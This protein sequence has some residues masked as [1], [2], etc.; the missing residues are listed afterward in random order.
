MK[1]L[2]LV[3]SFL[4]CFS[5]H[6]QTEEMDSLNAVLEEEI[7]DSTRIVVLTR[8]SYLSTNFNPQ[9]GAEIAQQAVSLAHS[10]RLEDLKAQALFEF[11]EALLYSDFYDSALTVFDSLALILDRV[12]DPKLSIH[13]L[14]EKGYIF[15][16]KGE[17]DNALE[18]SFKAL[19]LLDA[20]DYPRIKARV[21]MDIAEIFRNQEDG[22]SAL[23]YNMQA[24]ETAKE[25]DLKQ[26][27]YQAE[28][29]MANAYEKLGDNEKSLEIMES[30][31]SSYGEILNKDDSA[32]I[33]S[34]MANQLMKL[35]RWKEAESN[36]LNAL[37]LRK[38]LNF[39]K[40]TAYVLKSLGYLYNQTK[41]PGKAI[42]YNEQAYKIGKEIN[43]PYLLR[44]ITGTLATAYYKIGK[45]QKAF[46]MLLEQRTYRDQLMD[47][48]RVR[49]SQ[50]M[51]KKYEAEKRRQQIALQNEQI[52]TQQAR[53]S[54]EATLRNA[55]I[56]GSILLIV[57][58]GLVINRQKLSI[59]NKAKAKELAELKLAK[60]KDELELREQELLTYVIS[61]AQ[62]NNLLHNV[63]EVAKKTED[64]GEANKR[65]KKINHEIENGY[66][67]NQQWEEFREKFEKIHQRFFDRLAELA[68][69]L[70]NTDRRICAYLKLGL[71][72]KQISNLQ[73]VSVESV[74]VR[75][76]QIR[77][78][79]GLSKED[80]LSTYIQNIS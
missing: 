15:L 51:E 71:S 69:D 24:F 60:T 22:E 47:Q 56:G 54:K 9:K 44:D 17:I 46:D 1:Y 21:L 52:A 41:K 50:E 42:V 12:D 28:S 25:N 68:S 72:S 26:V 76:S 13:I 78:K 34:T 67:L 11:G 10:A 16:V 58:A 36:L 79:L 80:N 23:K 33:Y 4:F 39:P 2:L 73:N 30:L 29:N 74:E 66:N 64:L 20:A 49:A 7:S 61:I 40:S 31:M 5:L 55:I 43:H 18:S 62:K 70:T 6:A 3:I 63:K 77:G 45:H 57:I 75:R 19:E 14:V 38:E 8:L 65:L 35:D 32:S 37:K 48:E 53:I 59:R 27:M